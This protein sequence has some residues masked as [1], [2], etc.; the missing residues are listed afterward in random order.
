MMGLANFS[1]L[2]IRFIQMTDC[3]CGTCTVNLSFF[4]F[5]KLLKKIKKKTYL[6]GSDFN[7]TFKRHFSK[8]DSKS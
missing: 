5:S 3:T 2:T 1:N 8:Q 6:V 4:F 7:S